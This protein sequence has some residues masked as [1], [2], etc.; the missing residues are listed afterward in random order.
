MTGLQLGALGPRP[1]TGDALVIL[2]SAPPSTSIHRAPLETSTMA[3]FMKDLLK[4]LVLLPA[5]IAPTPHPLS[6]SEL[7]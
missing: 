4:V 2:A 5:T 3:L 7:R 6:S 1:A